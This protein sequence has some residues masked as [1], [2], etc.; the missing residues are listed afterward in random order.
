MMRNR[1]TGWCPALSPRNK[2]LSG[3]G[4]APGGGAGSIRG[5]GGALSAVRA[6]VAVTKTSANVLNLTMRPLHR[7]GFLSISKKIRQPAL[8]GNV[9][10]EGTCEIPSLGNEGAE[11]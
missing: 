11:R 3:R 9:K 4:A 8:P 7:R 1:V 10:L 2:S 5:A 6:T